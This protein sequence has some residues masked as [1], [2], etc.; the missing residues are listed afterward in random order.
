MIIGSYLLPR[1]PVKSPVSPF[2]PS[3]P[4]DS[5]ILGARIEGYY[6]WFFNVLLWL[7]S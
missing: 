5:R 6:Y 3:P 2:P 4:R 7:T 1:I